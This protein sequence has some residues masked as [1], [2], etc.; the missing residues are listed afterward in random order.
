V[1]EFMVSILGL[2]FAGAQR[3]C[4]AFGHLPFVGK[5][6]RTVQTRRYAR[7]Y[8]TAGPLKFRRFSLL[9]PRDD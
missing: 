9:N 1:T 7:H 2:S 4:E 8:A 3:L 5:A 6:I